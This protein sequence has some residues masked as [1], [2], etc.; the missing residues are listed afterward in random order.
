MVMHF[1]WTHDRESRG[2][3]PIWVETTW[4]TFKIWFI[5]A[6]T[7]TLYY[8]SQEGVFASL[9]KAYANRLKSFA[10]KGKRLVVSSS[11]K[12][13]AVSEFWSFGGMNP[14]VPDGSFPALG[15]NNIART[16]EGVHQDQKWCLFSG[17]TAV[18]KLQLLPL[19]PHCFSLGFCEHNQW[20]VCP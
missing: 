8:Y 9:K 13:R 4:T 17:T 7:L 2:V 19:F 1:A 15:G 3:M 18:K 20:Q 12:R 14:L 11:S 10:G 6:I 16:K 5:A